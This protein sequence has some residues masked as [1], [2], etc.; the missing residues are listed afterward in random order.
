MAVR[1]K[2]VRGAYRVLILLTNEYISNF[3]EHKFTLF[4][5][6]AKRVKRFLKHAFR[7]C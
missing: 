2:W 6:A 4:A 7:V 1:P 3:R 5:W